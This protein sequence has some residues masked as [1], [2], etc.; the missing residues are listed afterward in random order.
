MAVAPLHRWHAGEVIYED[1]EPFKGVIRLSRLVRDEAGPLHRAAAK[2]NRPAS[3]D[4][5]PFSRRRDPRPVAAQR[6]FTLAATILGLNSNRFGS[7]GSMV[8]ATQWVLPSPNVST[9]VKFATT[10]PLS[11]F[12]GLSSLK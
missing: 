2:L 11:Y 7:F 8:T 10:W 5:G 12:S 4:A 9:R 3:T 1:Y 6:S